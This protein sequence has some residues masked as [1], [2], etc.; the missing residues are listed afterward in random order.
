MLLVGGGGVDGRSSY[1]TRRVT[2][3]MTSARGGQSELLELG[4]RGAERARLPLARQLQQGVSERHVGVA[5]R[6]DIDTAR[7]GVH[8]G[9]SEEDG[10]VQHC[11]PHSTSPSGPVTSA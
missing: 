1:P 3:S 4:D 11:V 8:D 5:A 2:R 6:E 10:V 9:T 7:T